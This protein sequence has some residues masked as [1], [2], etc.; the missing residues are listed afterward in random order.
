MATP[1]FCPCA[2][3]CRTTL[4]NKKPAELGY[5]RVSTFENAVGSGN[6]SEMLRY[7]ALCKALIIDVRNNGGGMITSAE[8][9]ASHFVNAK[10][11]AGYISHKNGKGHSDFSSPKAVYL[12][13]ATGIRWLKL[14][15]NVCLKFSNVR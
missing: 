2:G 13:P 4:G 7:F 15:Y 11:L 5:M 9:L 3:L 14:K 1:C 6:V 12:T 8:K 10:A